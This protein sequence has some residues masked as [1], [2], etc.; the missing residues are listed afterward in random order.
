MAKKRKKARKTT[1]RRR[2]GGVMNPNGPIVKFGSIGAGYFLGDKINDAVDK[3]TGGKVDGKIVAGVMA[4][5]G[6]YL[7]FGKGKKT[8]AK[9]VAGGVLLGAGVKKGLKEFG[10]LNG[11]DSVPVLAGYKSVPVLNGYST[12]RTAMNG[13]NVP[14]P[15]H[16]SVMGSVAAEASGSGINDTDR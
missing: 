6:A 15:L 16:R 12:Q 11:F 7:A 9:Q 4:A 2:I 8:V 5:A 3:A 13:F 14:A 1:R 10:V